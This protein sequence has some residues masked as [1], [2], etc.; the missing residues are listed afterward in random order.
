M[1]RVQLLLILVSIMGLGGALFL[2]QTSQ[3]LRSRAFSSYTINTASKA[4]IDD[5]SPLASIPLNPGS[6]QYLFHELGRTYPTATTQNINDP[7]SQIRGVASLYYDEA[8]NKSF[9]FIRLENVPYF[10]LTPINL[11][12]S[13]SNR[14]SRASIGEFNIEDNKPVAYFV[15]V[16]DGDLKTK[17]DQATVSYEAINSSSPILPIITLGL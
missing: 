7:G 14:Y 5:P 3:D 13:N 9:A 11:W 4:L 8:I 6:A 15:Y 1:K 12:F 17:F 10:E 2:V 16:A